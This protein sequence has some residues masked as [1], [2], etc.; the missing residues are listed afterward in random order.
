LTVHWYGLI[1]MTAALVGSYV[2]AVEAKRRGENEDHV[3]NMLIIAAAVLLA[4]RHIGHSH[5]R[6]A[7]QN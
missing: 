3:W 7:E 6:P 1:I 4:I 2:A 5:P